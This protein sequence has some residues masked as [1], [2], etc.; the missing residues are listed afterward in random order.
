VR[1][2]EWVVSEGRSPMRRGGELEGREGSVEACGTAPVSSE[3]CMKRRRGMGRE[4][5]GMGRELRRGSGELRGMGRELRRG[6]GEPRGMGGEPRGMGRELRRRSGELR[7]MAGEPRR[8]GGEPQPCSLSPRDG[9]MKPRT[10]RSHA[11][12]LAALLLSACSRFGAVY[13]PR[14][15]EAPGPP[16]AEPA[17]ARLVVHVSM[18]ADALRAALDGAVPQTGEGDFPLL[19]SPRHYTWTRAPLSLHLAQG[20]LVLAIHVDAHVALPLEALSLPFD[21][22][23]AAE[24]VVNREYAV[25]LQSVDVKVSSKDRRLAVANAVA[26]VFDALGRE[27][28]Q[29]M[30]QFS[31]DLMPLVGDA[32]HRVV[33]PVP[34]PVGE[35]TACARV[36]VLGVEAGPTVLADGI[37]KDLALV[38]APEVTVPCGA[39]EAAAPLPPLSNVSVV[40]PGPF[41]VSVPVAAGYDDLARAMKAA[42]TDGKLFF[43]KDYPDLFL[44]NPRLYESQGLV[45][46][47]LHLTG[48]VRAAGIHADLDG[49]IFLSGHLTVADNELSIPDLE[50]TIETKNLLLSLKAA[51]SAGAIR[52]QARA[53]LRLDLGERLKS[54]RSA[55]ADDL[56]FGNKAACFHGDVDKIEVTG[57]HPHAAYLRVYVA[58]TGRASATMPCAAAAP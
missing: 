46:L 30:Q 27:V 32:Y 54:V 1:R 22:E 9:A 28:T 15:A 16:I 25:K 17:P 31:Y 43:S 58:V 11:A 8:M 29:R 52:D 2:G 23:V 56:T 10:M 13:P 47:E 41:T 20:K 53:A 44:E 40:P 36:K 35:T 21:L 42:F 55:L 5:R 6:S 45:V 38:V 4:P 49:N 24:P 37:E 7:R 39:D 14:P 57:A 18:T 19:G 34:I 50:P 33:R 3:G 51:T 26:G 48:P 12:L